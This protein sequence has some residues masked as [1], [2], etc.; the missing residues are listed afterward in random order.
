MS[1]ALQLAIITLVFGAPAVAQPLNPPAN[2]YMVSNMRTDL[3]ASFTSLERC[4]TAAAAHKI[5]AVGNGSVA[6]I[7]VCVQTQ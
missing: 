7:L 2:L 6:V 3:I 1:R 4:Q 5:I